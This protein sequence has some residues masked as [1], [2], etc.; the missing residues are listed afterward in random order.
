[1][2]VVTGAT[3]QLGRLV[4]DRLLERVPAASV[5]AAVRSPEKAA[6]LAARGVEIRQA[7]Y[8]RPES[9]K[10]ALAGADKVLLI[11]SNEV[12]KRAAQHRA[13]VAAAKE[14]G[15]SLLAYT[16]LTDGPD[17][18]LSLGTEH[19]ATERD[20]RDSG[21]PFTFLRNN[22]YTENNLGDLAGAIERG[23]IASN[24]GDGRIASATRD[25]FA[26][27]AAVV[28]TG[29]GH[30]NRV[31]ELTG[32]TAWSFADL[33]AEVSRQCGKP[34]AH[35]PVSDEQYHAILAG[36]GLPGPLVDVLVDANARIREGA[37]AT[38][39]DDLRTLIGRPTTP[40]DVAVKAALD[41]GKGSGGHA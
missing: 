11:S 22:W 1:M 4:I 12:G 41:G 26:A 33:A 2:I 40:L 21:L 18:P 25:D 27:A 35:Q 31:Y 14:T 37:L 23:A 28:L 8:D 24:A 38:V 32:D 36:V 34:V 15:V 13:V 19:G 6:D 3:G 9:F 10:A 5:V 17:S 16:S 39:T 29:E 30:E 20:I 7:D